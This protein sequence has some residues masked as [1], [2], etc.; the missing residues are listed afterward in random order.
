MLHTTLTALE[1][2]FSQDCARCKQIFTC[3]FTP[4]PIS[5]AKI[6]K[7]AFGAETAVASKHFNSTLDALRNLKSQGSCTIWALETVDGS[8]AYTNA[9]LPPFGQGG[10]ALLLGNE[11]TGVNPELLPAV[12]AIVEIPTYGTKNSMNVACCAATVIFDILR[13]WERH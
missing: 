11:V 2:P 8:Q 4:N 7:T 3:G 13:R 5:T 6:A 12:D 1:T 10:V 9:P